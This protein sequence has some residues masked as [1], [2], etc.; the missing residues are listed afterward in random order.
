ML[1]I[2]KKAAAVLKRTEE[3][4]QVIHSAPVCLP[5]LKVCSYYIYIAFRGSH[6][7]IIAITVF[8][9]VGLFAFDCSCIC[10]KICAFRWNCEY[11]P[12][13]RLAGR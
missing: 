9:F 5:H 10:Y 8:A 7:E 12:L 1:T 6:Y 11:P 3:L 4:G 2:I 13:F